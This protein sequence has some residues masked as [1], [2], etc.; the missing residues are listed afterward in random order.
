MLLPILYLHNM[1]Y[2]TDPM[3]QN[4][5][6]WLRSQKNSIWPK[7]I[8]NNIFFNFLK[9]IFGP[10][11][12]CKCFYPFYTCIICGI[13]PI[14]WLKIEKTRFGQKKLKKAR[15]VDIKWPLKA[16]DDFS[17]T[18]CQYKS[19]RYWWDL[20]KYAIWDRSNRS[21]SCKVAKTSILGHFWHK[22]AKIRKIRVFAQNPA[23]S[24][25]SHFDPVTSYRKS[26]KSDRGKYD[27]FN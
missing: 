9:N 3:T 5:K 25:Y 8:A 4:R 17:S 21:N 7:K 12:F 18:W 13:G 19:C 11:V 16:R 24:V 2:R 15:I 20:S 14:R 23:V 1:R 10:A 27:N 6:K 26:K 22:S